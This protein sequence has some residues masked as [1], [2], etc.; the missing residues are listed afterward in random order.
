MHQPCESRHKAPRLW[1]SDFHKVPRP[2]E[3]GKASSPQTVLDNWTA[4]RKGT[5]LDPYLTPAVKLIKNASKT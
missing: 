4:T 3:G 1:P 2:L 5:Q